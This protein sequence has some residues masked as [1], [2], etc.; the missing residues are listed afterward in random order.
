[1]H[2]I[3]PRVLVLVGPTCSGKTG[4]SMHLA[5]QLNGEVISAD[6]R[7]IYRHLDIGTAKPTP[8]ERGD[9]PHHFVDSLD[10]GEDFNAGRFGEE[11]RRVV[12]GILNRNK[13]PIIVGGSG[14]YVRSLIDGLFDGPGADKEFRDVLE[15]RLAREGIESLVD[16]L[17]RVDPVSA[18]RIDPTK[19][20]RVIRALEVH[21]LTGSPL[22]QLHALQ[23]VFIPFESVQFG[24]AWDRA[25]LN[26]RI[27]ARCDAMVASG[28]LDEVEK[29]ASMGWDDTLN[30]LNTV[31]YAEAF[32]LRRGEIPREEF[33][34]LF[35]QNSRRYAKRQMTWFRRDGRIQWM[36]MDGTQGLENVAATIAE[37][38]FGDASPH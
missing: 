7:Q 16:E 14:L 22:S 12:S 20:R 10:P 3:K 34:R 21:R 33:L 30:A 35:K 32:A 29:L 4:V 1:M 37:K 24:L 38:F 31:G 19:P 26:R 5:R 18:E 17:R 27:E 25:V 28:L 36:T 6:S 2:S 23:E 8:E 11:G 13:L 15:G 9:I